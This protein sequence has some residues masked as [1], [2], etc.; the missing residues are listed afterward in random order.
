MPEPAV[1]EPITGA[2]PEQMPEGPAPT[3]NAAETDDESRGRKRKRTGPPTP[4]G[5]KKSRYVAPPPT[6]PADL[7]PAL[8]PRRRSPTPPTRVVKSTYGGNLFTTE[9][10]TYLKKY[11]DWC[12]DMGE[13][14]SLRE[15]CERLAIK[16]AHHTFYSWRRYCNKHKI[17][18]GSYQMANP[19][20]DRRDGGDSDPEDDREIEEEVVPN[21]P[22]GAPTTNIVPAPRDRNRSPTP[23]RSLHRSTTGKG[24][25][26]TEED[27]TFLVRY[28]NYRREREPNLNMPQFWNDLATKAPHHSRASWL[29]YWRRHRH[30]IEVNGGDDE[31]G[32]PGISSVPL[33]VPQPGGN[34]AKR[35]RYSQADDVLLAKFWATN[36][37]GTSDKLFQAF[38]KQHPH[39][40]WKGWQEHHRIHKAQI[41]HLIRLL[42][43]GVDIDALPAPPAV[44]AGR[45]ASVREG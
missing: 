7:V 30:E 5:S 14:L 17:K 35:Q 31:E 15:I 19:E 12:V 8:K 41:D 10:I 1:Q 43:Q 18:L 27:V 29:K 45:Q 13:V 28:L 26:F 32:G 21:P 40:P 4:S 34:V 37:Q 20:T 3:E 2:E 22:Q 39:H 23:P 9:D 11:I 42:L 38:A 44:K 24:I 16:A 25:A 33:Q 36:P 6:N